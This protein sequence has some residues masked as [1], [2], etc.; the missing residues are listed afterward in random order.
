LVHD[1]FLIAYESHDF[2]D[3][4]ILNKKNGKHNRSNARHV[5]TI[6]QVLLVN[7]FDQFIVFFLFALSF[8]EKGS[9]AAIGTA[10]SYFP[11][12]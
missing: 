12:S 9:S 2:R 7:G 10:F 6:F 11:Y 4:W 5:S 1:A 3:L 8:Q